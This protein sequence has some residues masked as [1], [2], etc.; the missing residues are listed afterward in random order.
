MA[1]VVDTCILLDVGLD[2]EQFA[3][4]SELLLGERL[5]EGLLVCPV[6]FI[7]L[8]PAFSGNLEALQ[9][10]LFQLGVYHEEDWMM[11]DTARASDAWA[12][13]VR[14]RRTKRTP[15]RPVADVLIG[16]FAL[17]FEGLLTRNVR[18]FQNL[19]PQLAVV[20]P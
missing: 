15:K 19:F 13:H 3:S 10:F 5:R 18:D 14:R 6:T 7:E 20:S 12:L 8:A 4:R 2:D 16:A 17:R 11:A 9:E 1:W